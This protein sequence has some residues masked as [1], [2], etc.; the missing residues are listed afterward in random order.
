MPGY[1][2]KVHFMT[3]YQDFPTTLSLRLSVSVTGGGL[4]WHC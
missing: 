4:A 3:V 2:R 1:L